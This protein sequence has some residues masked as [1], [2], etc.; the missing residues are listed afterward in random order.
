MAETVLMNLLRGDAFRLVN[1]TNAT[2]G[3]KGDL[4]RCKPFKYAYEKEIVLYAYYQKLEYFST[5]CT[6][7]K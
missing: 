5:E 1:C 2:S 6:Y 3:E 7:S 4:L